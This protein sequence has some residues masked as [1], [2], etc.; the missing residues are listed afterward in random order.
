MTDAQK[1]AEIA[2]LQALGQVLLAQIIAL[3]AGKQN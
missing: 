3:Q 1:H 2:R